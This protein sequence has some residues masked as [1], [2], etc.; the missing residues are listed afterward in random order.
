MKNYANNFIKKVEEYGFK[1]QVIS[2]KHME[3]IKLDIENMKQTYEDINVNIGKYL[4][5]FDYKVS[6]DFLKPKSII[7][8]AVPQPAARVYFTLGLKKYAVIMPPM[9]LLNSSSEFEKKHKKI[10]EITEIVENILSYENFKAIKVNIPCKPLAVK[11]GLGAYGK[12]NICYINGESSFYWLGVYVSDMPWENDSWGEY[13]VMEACKNCDL[14]LKNCPTGAIAE[15]RFIVHANKCITL[16]NEDSGDFKKSLRPEWHN[17]LIG[18]MR[19]QIICPANKK[20]ITSIKDITEFN[21]WETR[22]ILAKTPL[23]ELPETT[24]KK[25]ES[26]SFIEDYKLLQR[27]LKVLIMK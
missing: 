20:C 4:N 19:C 6:D 12:N 23:E 3:E 1:A 16:Q 9:Y 13:T 17:C 22:K 15:D 5:K 24:Y 25:L 18:C 21:D 8:I 26:I 14:C 11:S 7:I 10:C 2:F 27:N